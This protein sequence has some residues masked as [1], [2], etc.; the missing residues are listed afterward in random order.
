MGDPGT[1]IIRTDYNS[2]LYVDLQDT[3]LVGY[4]VFGTGENSRIMYT[5]ENGVTA[6]VQF[7][8]SVPD[9]IQRLANFPVGILDDLSPP[10]I[11]PEPSTFL[12]LASGLGSLLAYAWT[13]RDR[14]QPVA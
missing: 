6:Y 8:Q 9:G 14:L 10:G 1:G 4:K 3:S 2:E 5:A 7:Q 11:A 13:K 12:L